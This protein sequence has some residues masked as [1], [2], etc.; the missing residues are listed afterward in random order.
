MNRRGFLRSVVLAVAAA[1]MPKRAF[2]RDVEEP[3]VAHGSPLILDDLGMDI[4]LI[5]DDLG[6][7]RDSYFAQLEETGEKITRYL[8]EIG[9]DDPDSCFYVSP[10]KGN[11]NGYSADTP[12]GS[13]EEAL[14][15][16][17]DETDTI[18]IIGGK[19]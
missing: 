3:L 19:A 10:G 16:C 5:V 6:M 7:D 18:Y 8:A 12:L 1:A 15:K 9:A 2:V 11:G 4:P 14:A 13:L 17:R